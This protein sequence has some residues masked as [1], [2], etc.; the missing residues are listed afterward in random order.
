M[1]RGLKSA[2][3][4][5]VF[6]PCRKIHVNPRSVTARWPPRFAGSLHKTAK[7]AVFVSAA[8]SVGHGHG[9]N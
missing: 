8:E 1:A 4:L 2:L 5:S 7:C 3:T 9:I 6:E